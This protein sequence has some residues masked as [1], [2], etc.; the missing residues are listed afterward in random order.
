[1]A[2]HIHYDGT[3]AWARVRLP[4]IH[5]VLKAHG[6]PY[7]PASGKQELMPLLLCRDILPTDPLPRKK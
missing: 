7:N 5:E 1:M 3:G 2:E 4:K 6:I